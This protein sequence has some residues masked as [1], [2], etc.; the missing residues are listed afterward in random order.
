[1]CILCVLEFSILEESEGNSIEIYNDTDVGEKEVAG[2]LRK[3]LKKEILRYRLVTLSD[4]GHGP[5]VSQ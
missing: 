1:M 4:R 5:R 2:I 3:K